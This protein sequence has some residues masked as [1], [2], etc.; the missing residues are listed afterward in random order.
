MRKRDRLGAA[1]AGC[2]AALALCL[3]LVVLA[4]AGAQA[5]AGSHDTPAVYEM[6]FADAD[7]NQVIVT[8]LFAPGSAITFHA[9]SSRVETNGTVVM[10]GTAT[11]T[12]DGRA[13]LIGPSFSGGMDFAIPSVSTDVVST[14][15]GRV[16]DVR[17]EEDGTMTVI[18][19]TTAGYRL[20][21]SHLSEA[22]V[23]AGDTVSYRQKIGRPGQSMHNGKYYGTVHLSIWLGGNEINLF[24]YPA[25]APQGLSFLPAGSGAPAPTAIATTTGTLWSPQDK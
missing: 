2:A 14:V 9:L 6:P 22:S 17:R 12:S 5:S 11:V 8:M 1:A 7:A 19:E 13:F 4:P 25:A 10:T 16:S 23:R 21:F 20:V 15:D 18:L 24:S 3:G